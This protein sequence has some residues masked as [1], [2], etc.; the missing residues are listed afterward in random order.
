[1][2]KVKCI[3][4]AKYITAGKIYDVVN[5][6]EDSFRIIYDDGD[7]TWYI[8][9]NKSYFREVDK[10]QP[11][12]YKSWEI[13]KMIQDGILKDHDIIIDKYNKW[14]RVKDI[15]TGEYETDLFFDDEDNVFTIRTRKYVTFD[16]AI[17]SKKY[18]KY[19]EWNV[20]ESLKDALYKL[21]DQY[22]SR[23]INNM[24]NEKA[25]EIED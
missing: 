9:Y 19:K 23:E 1:M 6:T 8:W 22:L 2:K 4:G 14:Y 13:V 17:K 3:N 20:F 15:R 25:W 11:Q 21:G 24:I 18:L 10:E 12:T 7:S 5:E 16:E